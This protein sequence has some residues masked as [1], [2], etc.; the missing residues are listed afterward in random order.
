MIFPF[1]APLIVVFPCFSYILPSFSMF[2]PIEVSIYLSSKA[3]EK[4]RVPPSGRVQPAP[5]HRQ[6]S[7]AVSLVAAGWLME[8]TRSHNGALVDDFMWIFHHYF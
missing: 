7:A 1:Q 6:L 4:C 8:A 5:F 2:F 3:G